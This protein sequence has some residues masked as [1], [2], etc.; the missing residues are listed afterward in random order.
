MYVKRYFRF[1]VHLC[2]VVLDNSDID[3]LSIHCPSSSFKYL[4]CISYPDRQ[5]GCQSI[6]HYWYTAF[7]S[8]PVDRT[9]VYIDKALSSQHR[10]PLHDT[11]HAPDQGEDHIPHLHI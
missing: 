4:L 5:V 11:G 9:L 8:L 3:L 10:N 6:F 7:Y 2:I 1:H